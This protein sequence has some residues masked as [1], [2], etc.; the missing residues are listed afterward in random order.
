MIILYI[1]VYYV[2]ILLENIVNVVNQNLLSKLKNQK[3]RKYNF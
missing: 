1:Y 3:R 2:M